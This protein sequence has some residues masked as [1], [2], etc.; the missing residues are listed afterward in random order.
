MHNFEG[1]C[2]Y[3]SMVGRVQE[4]SKHY[5]EILKEQ[6]GVKQLKTHLS[7]LDMFDMHIQLHNYNETKNS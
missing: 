2:N 7:F 3:I 4:G 1:S 6:F 5:K